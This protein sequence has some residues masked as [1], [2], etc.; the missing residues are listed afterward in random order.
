MQCCTS[1]WE[2]DVMDL[3]INRL[4]E[5][6][7]AATRYMESANAEKKELE[8]QSKANIEAYD[9]EVDANTSKELQ[10]LKERLDAKMHTELAKLEEKTNHIITVIEEDYKMNHKKLAGNVFNK[11]IKE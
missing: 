6:E 11:L 4:S 3:V 7:A 10:A 1:E 8:K 5:I 9:A 2:E